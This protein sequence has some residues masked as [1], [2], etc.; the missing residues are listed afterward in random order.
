MVRVIG[1]PDSVEEMG[2]KRASCMLVTKVKVDDDACIVT[3]GSAAGAEG[4]RKMHATSN[5][6]VPAARTTALDSHLRYAAKVD[7]VCPPRE[8]ARSVTAYRSSARVGGGM[9]NLSASRAYRHYRAI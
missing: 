7:R 3:G 6:T 1:V 5:R 8:A 4:S 2:V 9:R